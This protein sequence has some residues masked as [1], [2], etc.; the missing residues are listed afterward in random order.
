MS[1]FRI[2][3][4]S[5]T[6]LPHDLAEELQ[7]EV[8]PL[9]FYLNNKE[10]KNYL[11]NRELDPKVFY[12]EV[13]NGAQPTTSQ[14]NADEFKDKMEPFLKNG[15]DL[16]VLAFSSALSGTYNSARIAC[17]ELKELYPERKIMLIDTKSASLGE[18]LIVT[19]AARKRLEGK[20]I[21]ETYDYVLETLPNICHWFTVD[22][23]K[24][25]RRGGRISAVSSFVAQTLN[26]KPVLYTDNEGRLIPRTKS[27]GR[28][29]ALKTLVEKM[30][31]RALKGPQ[32]VYI[33]HGD[34]IEDVNY[35]VDLIKEK[36][37]IKELVINTIGPVVGSHTGQGV[38][39]LFFLGEYR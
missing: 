5:T 20:T 17:D 21:E 12:K 2:I 27:I 9:K 4:D 23:I 16:L 32:T 31:E 24:H 39:A 35:L 34:S 26:I 22:D 6:D 10:Y 19:L 25:L 30:E 15:E 13:L 29:K 28:K 18:G 7:L 33:G 11:D 14:V 8:L 38:I 1:K 3:T 37:E 36:F